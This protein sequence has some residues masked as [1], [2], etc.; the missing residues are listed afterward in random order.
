LKQ[1][2]IK[3]LIEQIAEGDERA[4]EQ[5]FNA[6]YPRFYRYA[7]LY[8]NSDVVCEELVSDV[9]L[10][11]WNSRNKLVDVEHIEFYLFKAVKNQVLTYLKKQSIPFEHL[12]NYKITNLVE[13]NEPENLIINRE[14]AQQIEKMIAQ[15]PAK[16]QTIFRMV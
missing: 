7:F 5:F 10:K 8:L 1:E 9:F 14:L 4:F 13:Y 12:T 6:L 16:C 2:E 15:L 3:R 11:L